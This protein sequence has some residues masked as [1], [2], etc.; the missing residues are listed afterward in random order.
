MFNRFRLRSGK[1]GDTDQRGRTDLKALTVKQVPGANDWNDDGVVLLPN[2]MPEDLLRKYEQ[3]WLASNGS[4]TVDDFEVVLPM[5]WDYCTPYREHTEILDLLTWGPLQEQMQTLVGEPVGTH[6]NLTGWKTTTRAWHQDSYLN[7]VH[8]GDYYIAAWIALETVNP[9]SGPFQ[10][11]PGSHRWPQVT[12]EKIMNALKPE[13]RNHSWPTAS[14][15]I[16]TPLFTKEIE[17]RGATVRSYLPNRGDVLLWHGRL[18][19][20]GSMAKD[21]TLLRR[22]LIAHFSGINHRSDMPPAEQY[23]QGWYFPVDDGSR[24]IQS[25]Q[26]DIS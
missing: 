9:D 13:E 20:Q 6:L 18:L 25:P 24:T 23:G 14:E 7:P 26:K 10:Y 22:S 8:V 1:N 17:R 16:L 2:F 15:R 19:H 21:P 11:V 5:G 4:G 3:C 12:Q